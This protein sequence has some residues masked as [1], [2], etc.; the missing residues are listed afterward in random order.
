MTAPAASEM[1]R[2][3]NSLAGLVGSLLLLAAPATSRAGDGYCQITESIP[4]VT[5][6]EAVFGATSPSPGGTCGDGGFSTFCFQDPTAVPGS[7]SAT[8]DVQSG[9]YTVRA[10]N[11]VTLPGNTANISAMFPQRARIFWFSE[12]TT[13]FPPPDHC[14]PGNFPTGNGCEPMAACGISPD[15]DFDS[16]STFIEIGGLTCTNLASHPAVRKYSFTVYVCHRIFGSCIKRDDLTVDLSE[17]VVRALLECSNDEPPPASCQDDGGAVAGSCCVGPGGSAP[18]VGAGEGPL[19]GGEASRLGGTPRPSMGASAAPDRAAPPGMRL[20]YLAGGAGF[21]GLPEAAAWGGHL[22]AGWSHPFARRIV[23]APDETSVWMITPAGTFRRF[24][25]LD[26][27]GFYTTVSPS[28]EYRSLEWL[29]PGWVLHGLDGTGIHFRAD[30]LWEKTVDRTGHETVGTYDGTPRLTGVGFPDGRALV[31]TYEPAGTLDTVTEVGVDP[32]TTRTWSYDWTG[33]LLDRIDRP[34]GTAWTFSYAAGLTT[35]MTHMRLESAGGGTARVV[36]AWEYTS[37]DKLVCAW[38]NAES[39]LDPEALER[40]QWDYVSETETDLIDPYGN[41]TTYTHDRDPAS[42]KPRVLSM[43]GDCPV[44]GG[45]S[46]TTT[47][48]YDDPLDPSHPLLPWRITDAGGHVTELAYDAFGRAIL[49]TEALGTPEQRSTAWTYDADYPAFPTTVARPTAI[50]TC[51]EPRTVSMVY[52]PATGN[53]TSRTASGC[54]QAGDTAATS[55]TT[56][57]DYTGTTAGQPTAIDPPGHG[58]ADVTGFVYDPARGDQVVASRSDPDPL[59]PGGTATTSFD[60]DAFNRRVAVTDPNGV[61]TETQYD[62]LDRVRFIIQR[63]G[64]LGID[65]Q[66]GDPPNPADLATEHRYNAFGDLDLTILPEGNAIDYGHDSAGRVVTVDRREDEMTPAA[67]RT[68]YTLDTFGRRTLEDLQAF[69]GGGWVS[70]SK[71]GF[72]YANRCHL[73]QVI[74]NPDAAPVDQEITEYGYDCDGN[75]A[76]IW[77]A[78]HPR[79]GLSATEY[80]YDPLHR[81]IQVAQRWGGPTPAETCPDAQGSCALTDYGYDAQDH[82]TTVTDPEGNLTGY[83]YNDRDLLV[84]EV[85]PVAGT[86]THTHDEHGE[87][88]TSL[89][90]RGVLTARIVDAADRVTHVDYGTDDALDVDYTYGS[91]ASRFEIGRL[92]GITRGGQTVE[93]EYDEF[94]RTTRDGELTYGYDENGNRTQIGYPG[95]VTATYELDFA[96]R[97]TALMVDDGV[98]PLETV[99]SG[100]TYAPSGPLTA[101]ALG[102]GVTEDRDFDTRYQPDGLTAGSLLSWDYSTDGV[103]NIESIADLLTPT[104]SRTYG[105][106]EYQYFLTAADGPW[107]SLAWTYDL[108]GNRLTEDRD[109]TVDS[110]TYVENACTPPGPP[111]HPCPGNTATLDSIAPGAGDT[112]D[113]TFG[114]A[115]H[116]QEV[117]AGA[118]QVLFDSDDEGRLSRL[119]RPAGSESATLGY[120]GRSFLGSATERATDTIFEDGF[121]TGD[122]GCWSN[123]VGG[124]GGPSGPGCFTAEASRTR[125]LYDSQGLLHALRRRPDPLTA[126]DASYVFYLAGR[127]VAQLELPAAGG[128]TWT[129]LT[130]DHLGTPVLATDA[131]G[132]EVWS[133]GVEPFGEDWQ[134]GTANGASENGVFLRLPGQWSDRSWEEASLGAELY[135]NVHRWYEAETGRFTRVDPLGLVPK[136]DLRVTGGPA[137]PEHLFVLAR[138]NPLFFVDELGL[139]STPLALPAEPTEDCDFSRYAGSGPLGCCSKSGFVKRLCKKVIDFACKRNPPACC[140]T[141]QKRCEA[142]VDLECDEA[143][144]ELARCEAYWI[145]CTAG[146]RRVDCAKKSD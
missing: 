42:G 38:R 102:N 108:T 124:P 131:V 62:A 27:S 10:D 57:F 71:T 60:Y 122:T 87:L 127:P 13:H 15:L 80:L 2:S 139:A 129:Y 91:Q 37:D 113:Y 125:P 136:P 16:G 118:N 117:L 99:A 96:D 3:P 51:T 123:Q 56:F 49:R 26:G 11:P 9:T 114:P 50:A 95:G 78:E 75:L 21:A 43:V 46:P 119:L 112:R 84:Q 31:L 104:D 145:L 74:H 115:G 134:A 109:A 77:D 61:T 97:E 14:F 44:C 100:A 4:G 5:E 41:V 103:G 141:E 23:E 33:A 47:T 53:L 140:L 143:D 101:L 116:L 111:G 94:G 90:A 34:D 64:T 52:D 121:E 79:P 93:Y 110:Y 45:G 73:D 17:P 58:T 39:C 67:E 22:G 86:T 69:E 55:Y 72:V 19:Q 130:T 1:F 89:D 36:A 35:R 40:W 29:D 106:Q 132:V 48:E 20:V 7:R 12:G 59:L 85:S 6:V 107:G 144:E 126:E 82:L 88:A 105:Y 146:Q 128:A 76:R 32:G 135:F 28:D 63:S 68:E 30:G 25:G 142:C 120:D 70:R 81:V 138:Q 133:G 18:A 54:E 8:F 83:V 98:N 137:Q 24:T 66:L 65:F 92:T